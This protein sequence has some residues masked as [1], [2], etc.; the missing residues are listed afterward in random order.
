MPSTLAPIVLLAGLLSLL[1]GVA[2]KVAAY[3]RLPRHLRWEL[4][5]IPH[6]GARAA[7][8]GSYLENLDWW[9]RPLPHDR[10][11][12]LRAMAGEIVLLQGVREHNRRLWIWS[13]PF[14]FGLYLLVVSS[15][16]LAGGGLAEALGGIPLAGR[17]GGWGTVHVATRW[18]EWSGGIL[19]TAGTLGLIGRRLGDRALRACTPPAAMMNL[20]FIL[21]ALVVGLAARA[22]QDPAAELLRARVGAILALRPGAPGPALIEAELCLAGILVGYLPYTFMSHAF[23]KFF[24]WHHVRWDDR[25]RRPGDPDDPRLARHLRRPVSWSAP[26]VGGGDGRTWGDVIAGE[27]PGRDGR[28]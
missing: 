20:G 6:E 26:H 22:A 18:L 25:P 28:T 2:A 27:A 15:L 24:T 16:L 21:A 1:V 3:L 4:Y 8:G 10:G 12:M 14:H 23:M 5:P 7:W 13:F 9:T 17:G 11:A 19:A